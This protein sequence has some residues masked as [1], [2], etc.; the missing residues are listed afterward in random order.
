M[1]DLFRK[2]LLDLQLTNG[3]INWT[4]LPESASKRHNTR[5]YRA[6]LCEMVEDVLNSERKDTNRE[7]IEVWIEWTAKLQGLEKSHLLW[8]EVDIWKT[9]LWSKDTNCELVEVWTKKK[10]KLTFTRI[11]LNYCNIKLLKCYLRS[12]EI[13]LAGP[14]LKSISH[15]T[16]LLRY[17]EY[18]DYF[19]LPSKWNWKTSLHRY[20]L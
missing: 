18:N 10:S 14:V 17:L 11:N 8:Y 9:R 2:K 7:I 16:D 15:R 19:N 20:L 6:C 4:S 13:N 12:D 5:N 1:D 3:L